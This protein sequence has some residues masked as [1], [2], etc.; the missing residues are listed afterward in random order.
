MLD[1][2]TGK[3]KIIHPGQP[4]Q[5]FYSYIMGNHQLLAN[6]NR[7]I[8]VSRNG[9][10]MEINKKGHKV[11]QYAQRYDEDYAALFEYS[12]RIKKNYFKVKNW[13]C[14]SF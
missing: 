5:Y 4:G 3:T 2:K 13:E 6:G 14:K 8:T 9:S 11:W 7:L 12:R 1:P 10:V